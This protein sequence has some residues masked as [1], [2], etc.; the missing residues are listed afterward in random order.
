MKKKFILQ[1]VAW[2]LTVA[3]LLPSAGAALT[4]AYAAGEKAAYEGSVT[5]AASGEWAEKELTMKD[6][7][8]SVDPDDVAYISFTSDVKFNIGYNPADHSSWK[9]ANYS[10]KHDVT[11]IA[12]DDWFAF[13][14]ALNA[15]DGKNYTIKWSVYT[16][17]AKTPAQE[18]EEQDKML[19]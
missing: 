15:N 5:Y 8:G 17:D 19:M 2:L 14:F 10:T 6:L 3:M 18:Q 13:K 16:G 11:D 9:W 1:A 4:T 7:I 12:L